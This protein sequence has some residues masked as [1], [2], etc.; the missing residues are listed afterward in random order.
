MKQAWTSVDYMIWEH[1]ITQFLTVTLRQYQAGN[2]ISDID[3]GGRCG[4]G[5]GLDGNCY[6]K[7]KM[8]MKTSVDLRDD[9]EVLFLMIPT[10]LT[11]LTNPN[12]P[13]SPY[14]PNNPNNPFTTQIQ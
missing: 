8:G 1:G 10:T 14:N 7:I 4:S 13:N 6:D 11:I 9:A 5:F 3:K 12:N 2:E